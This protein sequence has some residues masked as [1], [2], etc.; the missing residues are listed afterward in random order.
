MGRP[1]SRL[2]QDR[3]RETSAAGRPARPAEER[4]R[5]IARLLAI[6]LVLAAGG[7]CEGGRGRSA[8]QTTAAPGSAAPATAG[9]VGQELPE[10]YLTDTIELIRRQAYYAGRV[11]WPTVRAEARRRAGAAPT[12]TGVYD[13]I[14][15]VL[16]R[17]GDHHSFLLTPEQASELASG[18]GQG[19]GLTAL[20]PER[21]VVDVEPDGAAARAGV[22]VGDLVESVDGR[23]VQ[24]DEVVTLPPPTTG[25]RPAR[26][27]LAL[28][29]GHGDRA[30]RLE[31]VVQAAPAPAVRPPT[32]RRLSSTVGLL[33]LFSVARPAG[34]D[35]IRYVQTAHDAIRRVATRRTCGWVVDLRRNTG[36]SLPPML[37]AVGPTLGDG[38]AVG[39]RSRGGAMTWYGYRDGAVSVDD[40]QGS[41]AV[42]R[43]VRPPRPRPPVAVLTSRLTASAGEGVAVAFRGRPAVR[44]F[45][46]P[47]A[48]VPTGNAQYRLP[49]GAE[50]YLTGGIGVDRT[51][52]TYETRIRPDQPVA[53]DWTRYSTRADPVLEAA[54]A[55]LGARCVGR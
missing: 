42:S 17:L 13:A 37:T 31:I 8:S 6:C 12:R 4:R 51:G 18:G 32:A 35:A 48:G 40:R 19:F 1:A 53:T 36:G 3:R 14:R 39:F 45:G 49:D 9:T 20:F 55:W 16:S 41:P 15:W 22:R 28:R 24:G 46:E 44:S 34:P 25:G 50:L 23:P 52:R 29:R 33:E 7:A 30:R 5:R 54:T 27:R 2:E 21:V 47:T 26:V 11:D 43:P 10:G 38:R